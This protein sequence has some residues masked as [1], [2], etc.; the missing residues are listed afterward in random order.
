[1]DLRATA[2]HHTRFAKFGMVGNTLGGL[3][4]T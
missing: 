1:M 3:M 2:G 4:W